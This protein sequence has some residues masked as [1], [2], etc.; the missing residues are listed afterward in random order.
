MSIPTPWAEREGGEGEGVREGG[1]ERGGEKML[2]SVRRVE[3]HLSL[4]ETC[5][6]VGDVFSCSPC[7][8]R[9]CLALPLP[10]SVPVSPV[11]SDPVPPPLPTL[12]GGE[13]ERE[14]EREGRR[15]G[16]RERERE[17]ERKRE[18]MSQ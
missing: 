5:F 16:E 11:P 2:A 4:S 6:S 13:R 1:R 18:V 14:R 17:G 7:I 8:C 15:E 12:R 10:L 9:S 3:R